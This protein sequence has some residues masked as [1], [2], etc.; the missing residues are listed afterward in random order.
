MCQQYG[1][2][3]LVA[4]MSFRLETSR[5]AS[6]NV[7]CFLRPWY[8]SLSGSI[9][10]LARVAKSD[11]KYP[12][13]FGKKKIYIYIERERAD[14]FITNLTKSAVIWVKSRQK[15]G[16]L[17]PIS[18]KITP[19][20][21]KERTKSKSEEGERRRREKNNECTL[22]FYNGCSGDSSW[23]KKKNCWMEKV[24]LAITFSKTRLDMY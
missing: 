21:E 11:K 22:S 4:W 16:F 6:R 3:A 10:Q 5:M 19:T 23:P 18:S 9:L 24:Y 20:K 17:R 12:I 13:L 1:V 8:I 2:S 15:P 14:F 7:G